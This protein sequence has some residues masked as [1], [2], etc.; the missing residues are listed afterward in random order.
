MKVTI[1]N[2]YKIEL[3]SGPRI[4]VFGILEDSHGNTLQVSFFAPRDQELEY[5]TYE[6]KVIRVNRSFVNGKTYNNLVYDETSLKLL[7]LSEPVGIEEIFNLSSN[8]NKVDTKTQIS[9]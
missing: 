2:K 6:V 5:G 1:I 7:H 4:R 9:E 8:S 3:A